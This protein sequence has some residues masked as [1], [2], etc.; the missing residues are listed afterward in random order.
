MV[1]IAH[2]Q[3]TQLLWMVATPLSWKGKGMLIRDTPDEGPQWHE[4]TFLTSH[5]CL[6][7][8]MQLIL[9][10]GAQRNKKINN[11]KNSVHFVLVQNLLQLTNSPLVKDI[12]VAHHASGHIWWFTCWKC[13]KWNCHSKGMKN[14][15]VVMDKLSSFMMILKLTS[16]KSLPRRLREYSAL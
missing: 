15:E 10:S 2:S 9:C 13:V 12:E 8:F 11:P 6:K 5:L 16:L 1:A 3:I 4:Q 7:L 14:T